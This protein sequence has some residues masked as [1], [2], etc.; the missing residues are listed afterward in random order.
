MT[1]VVQFQDTGGRRRLGRKTHQVGARIMALLKLDNK[2]FG[3]Q[4]QRDGLQHHLA[5]VGAHNGAVP[6]PARQEGHQSVR[7]SRKQR[8]PRHMWP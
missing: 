7:A 8:R 6:E 4:E 5:Q 3:L 2:G 1:S